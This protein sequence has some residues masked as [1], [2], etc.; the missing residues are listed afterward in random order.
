MRYDN[1]TLMKGRKERY[2]SNRTVGPDGKG[3]WR[4]QVDSNSK[5]GS[6]H[7]TQKE[8]IEAAKKK[9]E[10]RGGEL[11]IKG[12]NGRIRDKNTIPP[13][14]DPRSSKG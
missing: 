1:P 11:T 7:P 5:N 6:T 4:E 13:A 10:D 8:A 3:K 9:M 2:V 14:N 12:R